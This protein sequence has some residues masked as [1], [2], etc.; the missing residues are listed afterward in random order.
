MKYFISLAILFLTACKTPHLPIQSKLD[1]DIKAPI[2]RFQQADLKLGL[3]IS[4]Y[5]GQFAKV[6]HTKN[7]GIYYFTFLI[8]DKNSMKCIAV[9]N[10]KSHNQVSYFKRF[11]N[12]KNFKPPVDNTYKLGETLTVKIK[13][14]AN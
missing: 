5:I 10:N 3:Y 4:D 7:Y 1:G 14:D 11:F 8:N 2:N 6:Y 12:S 13:I 9:N